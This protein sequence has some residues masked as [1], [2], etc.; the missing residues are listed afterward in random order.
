[1]Q[2]VSVRKQINRKLE[3]MPIE[4]QRKVLIYIDSLSKSSLPYGVSGKKLSQFAGVL[5]EENAK[6]LTLIIEE[7]CERI[8]GNEWYIL[9]G[10]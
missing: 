7:G 3:I 8:D 2:Q 4:M 5:T 10:Y 9:T 6:E 1:M